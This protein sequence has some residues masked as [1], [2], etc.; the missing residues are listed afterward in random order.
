MRLPDLGP[1]TQL[2]P[3]GRAILLAEVLHAGLV[4]HQE[5]CWMGKSSTIPP[6]L[7]SLAQVLSESLA[8]VRSLTNAS[9]SISRLPNEILSAVFEWVPGQVDDAS[10]IATFDC[11]RS[12][13]VRDAVP[14]TAVCR[15]WR[16]VALATPSLWSTVCDPKAPQ[17]APQHSF[18]TRCP[19]GALT[20]FC[21]NH[22]S[23]Y[24][25]SI[26][27]MHGDR[28]R[29]LYAF[30]SHS[31][32][33]LQSPDM[34]LP[35][36]E[37][38]VVQCASVDA[39]IPR[40]PLLAG[41]SVRLRSLTLHGA[42]FLPSSSFPSL[43]HLM[44]SKPTRLR[45]GVLYAVGDLLDFISGSPLL[46]EL[47]LYRL[48]HSG[49][50]TTMAGPPARAELV[51]LAR[52]EK[53]CILETQNSNHYPQDPKII[54]LLDALL[55]RVHIPD[56]CMVRI[57]QLRPSDLA[58]C[59]GCLGPSRRATR[60][61]VESL[62]DRHYHQRRSL[63]LADPERAHYTRL[64][65]SLFG[66]SEG[67]YLFYLLLALSLPIFRDV[68]ELYT[69]SS[70]A[71]GWP[72]GA[73]AALP[74]LEVVAIRP[75]PGENARWTGTTRCAKDFIGA[76]EVTKSSGGESSA[77]CCPRLATLVCGARPAGQDEDEGEDREEAYLRRLVGSRENAGHPLRRLLVWR[78]S[79]ESERG[80]REY[81]GDGGFV[82][83]YEG[84]EAAALACGAWRTPAPPGCPDW[85]EEQMYHPSVTV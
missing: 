71:Y 57:G 78:A 36:L 32:A 81:G 65:V 70:T 39:P 22:T 6:L 33:A 82:R 17:L 67:G 50:E 48:A 25:L 19:G 37:H 51:R 27:R 38:C 7:D 18:H 61:C 35:N 53:L 24:A 69:D 46:R 28:V 55:P 1:L 30:G 9:A 74:L 77:V 72:S 11:F 84:E 56:T 4:Q 79:G 59:L 75:M 52:L 83:A 26:L 2:E 15:W 34:S 54:P 20:V 45:S 64:D 60:M 63:V 8:I 66:P 10:R 31:L 44:I 12:V 40:L 23:D 41:E 3:E 47:H 80:L 76:L 42:S 14:L 68:R 85:M 58:K 43:T 73:F 16:Q 29:Q 21:D 13:D 62:N 5:S 49:V